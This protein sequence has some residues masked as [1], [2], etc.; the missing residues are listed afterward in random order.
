[1]GG[2]ATIAANA[3]GEALRV[4]WV[5]GK[6]VEAFAFHGLAMAAEDATDG[7]LQIDTPA[8]AVEITDISWRLIIKGT[9]GGAAHAA[10]CFFR[11]RRRE[12]TTAYG[13]PKMPRTVAAGLKPGKE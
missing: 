5:V 11:R 7:E 4:V 13:S 12:M 6:P 2:E 8:A 1:M 3:N 9:V 10:A